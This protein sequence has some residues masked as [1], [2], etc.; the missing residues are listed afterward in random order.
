MFLYPL[1]VSVSNNRPQT[2]LFLAIRQ[3][4]YWLQIQSLEHSKA[5]ICDYLYG[6]Q[7][8]SSTLRVDQECL[9]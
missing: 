4:D 3:V 6:F 9:D 7:Q 8:Q 2:L 1:Y 5:K